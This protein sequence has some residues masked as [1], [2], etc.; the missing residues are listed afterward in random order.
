MQTTSCDGC[1]API[2][3]AL[4][5]NGKRMPIDPDPHPDGNVEVEFLGAEG[6][7]A[8]VLK[9]GQLPWPGDKPLYRTH[10]ASCPDAMS[11]R[12]K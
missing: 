1:G 9:R 7:V 3:W 10:F 4:S 5:S 12:R 11:F 8:R 6:P 2:L